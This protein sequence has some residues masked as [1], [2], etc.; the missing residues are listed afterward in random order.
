MQFRHVFVC[1]QQRPPG[2]PKGCCSDRAGR[3]VLDRLFE[4]QQVDADLAR[5]TLMTATGCLGA[6]SVGPV[7]VVYPDGVWYGAVK[8]ADVDEIVERHLK[9][10]QVVDRLVL[11]RGKPP[12]ML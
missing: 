11:S 12:G 8:P 2:H 9:N 4:R 6:C 1:V 3:E 5:N 7:I 10:G